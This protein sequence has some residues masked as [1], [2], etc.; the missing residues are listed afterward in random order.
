MSAPEPQAND[1]ERPQGPKTSADPTPQGD[2]G[3]GKSDALAL[4]I[5]CLVFCIFFVAIVVV[6]IMRD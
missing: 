4:G 6:S 3:P 1:V 5:G 2:A